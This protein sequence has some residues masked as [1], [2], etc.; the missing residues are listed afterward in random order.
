MESLAQCGLHH[1]LESFFRFRGG[2]FHFFE[3]SEIHCRPLFRLTFEIREAAVDFDVLGRFEKRFGEL[4]RTFAVL[5]F[6]RLFQIQ[7]PLGEL[8]I[9]W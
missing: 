1:V 3:R 2:R 9:P 6:G 4:E 7:L 8:G 5:V